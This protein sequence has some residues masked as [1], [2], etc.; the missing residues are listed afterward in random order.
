M[1]P[2]AR[3][4][5]VID[6]AGAVGQAARAGGAP[7]DVILRDYFRPRR[8]AGSKD[9]RA[10]ADLLFAVLR[11]RVELDWRLDADADARLAVLLHLCLEGETVQRLAALFAG[12]DHAP[13]PPSAD[14]AAALEAAARRDLYHAPAWARLNF[15]EWLQPSFERRFGD[16]LEAEMAALDGRAPLDLRVNTLRGTV[17]QAL[18]ALPGASQ[19]GLLA[20]ALR[21]PP[22]HDISH[23]A[24]YLKGVVEIQDEASQ[25]GAALAGAAP[26]LQVLDLCAGGGGKALAMAARM[27]SRGQIFAYDADPKRLERMRPRAKRAGA[28]NI[29][30]VRAAAALPAGMDR[31][32]LDVPCSGTGTWRRSPE[33]RTRLTPDRLEGLVRLQDELLDRGA[34]LVGPGGRLVYMTCSLLPEEDEDRVAAFLDRNGGFRAV[35]YGDAWPAEEGAPPATL[36]AVPDYLV[37]SPASHRTD[38]FFVAVLQRSN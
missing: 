1:R 35:P 3:I 24:I 16:R 18:A 33:L 38:G 21:L 15:P 25:A 7:A 14:E 4:Q 32:V 29:Q 28:T 36:S 31:V 8:Y 37:L 6:L 5:A 20:T 27:A 26:G 10:V 19:G 23:E 2:G 34:A 9:R 30:Y 13:A 17:E 11:R 22:G 12:D